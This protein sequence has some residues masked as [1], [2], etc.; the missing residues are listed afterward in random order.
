MERLGDTLFMEKL[1]VTERR[2]VDTKVGTALMNLN[3]DVILC[4]EQNIK[5]HK[6]NV[7]IMGQGPRR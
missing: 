4:R 1:T 2:E 7:H 5:I 3:L 6:G